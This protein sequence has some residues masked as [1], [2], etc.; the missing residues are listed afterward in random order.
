MGFTI[1]SDQLIWFCTLVAGL[2]G[3]WKIV[4]EVRKP[5]QDLKDVVM[6]VQLLLKI[7]ME[8]LVPSVKDNEYL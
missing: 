3:L 1:S 8:I 6:N 5:N 2:W 7:H 4:K